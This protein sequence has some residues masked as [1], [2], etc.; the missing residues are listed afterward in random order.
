MRTKEQFIK[1][2]KAVHGNKYNY[3]KVVYKGCDK[4]VCIICPI[5]GEFWQTPYNHINKGCG[6]SKCK[7]CKK[8]T[9]EEFI[10]R[11]KKIHGN[12]YDYSKVEYVNNHTKVCIICPIHGE[13]WQQPNNHLQGKSCPKC[14]KKGIKYT[15]DEFIEMSN[16]IH[17]GK[18]D[19]S[20]VEYVNSATKVC[21][22]CPIHGEFWQTPSEHLVGYGCSR[23]VRENFNLTT[24]EFIQRAQKIHGNKYD[25]S[26]VKYEKWNEKVCIICPKHGEFWQTPCKH[27]QGQSCPK[28]K[29]SHL[30]LFT[31][32]MLNE[33]NIKY[34]HQA[35]KHDL[36]WL[37]NQRIDIFLPQYNIA[38][39]CQGEQHYKSI[40]IWNGEEGLKRRM[41]LDTI[42][43]NKCIEH[44]VKIYYVGEERYAKKYNLLTI[45]ELKEK[46][47]NGL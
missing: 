37:G 12:K 28:C 38:I 15:L 47:I 45:K 41:E 43:L 20:K 22:I 16:V 33:N 2:A 35:N 25:Y 36:K 9:T 21:I 44:G 6:C 11:A 5:H 4:K 23:C 42:K 10:E 14:S 40:D 1:E 31:I 19:Y 8:L 17:N 30:E 29:S 26:K 34:I 3:S 24:E 7:R 18:Y 39:E 32:K 13:F 46:L 27:L